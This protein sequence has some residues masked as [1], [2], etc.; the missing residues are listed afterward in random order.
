MPIRVLLADDHAF[1]REALMDLLAGTDDIDVVA[2]CADGSEVVPA[3]A[4]THV[5]VV[6]MDLQM[7]K[8]TGLEATRDLL[9]AYPDMR[10]IVLTGAFTPASAIEAQRSGAVG[11]L[12]KGDPPDELLDRIR[13]VAAGGTAWCDAAAAALRSYH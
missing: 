7:P 2:T 5:D 12:L 9:A 11:L 1:V 4:R 6:L 10:V 3:A 8:R 13:A